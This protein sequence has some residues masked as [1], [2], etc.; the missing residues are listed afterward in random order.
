MSKQFQRCNEGGY[1]RDFRPNE[2]GIDCI[3]PCKICAAE[4]QQNTPKQCDEC[5][6]SPITELKQ[7]LAKANRDTEYWRNM[8]M[9]KEW[10]DTR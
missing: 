7:Q 6:F 8:A 3:Q 9:K 2:Y 4:K 1:P 10:P 5:P